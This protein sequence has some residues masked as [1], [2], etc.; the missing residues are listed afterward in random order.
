MTSVAFVGGMGRSGSTLLEQALAATP[1]VC[2]L[3]EVVHLWRRGVL[4]DELCS[5]GRPFSQ[6]PFWGAVGD[7]AFGGWRRADAERMIELHDRVDRMRFLPSLLAGDR[8]RRAADVRTYGEAFA[9]IYAAAAEVSGASLVVDSSK[10]AST[11]AV[12]RRTA[13]V[14]LKIVHVVRDSRGVAYSW[15]T[16][17]VRPE[18]VAGSEQPYMHRYR[19][20]ESAVLWDAH[21]LGFAA[22]ARLGVPT[23]RVHYEDLLTAPADRLRQL[24]EF[25]GLD[26]ADVDGI[27]SESTMT[28]S[29]SHQVSGNPV[30]FSGRRAVLQTDDRWRAQLPAGSRALVGALTAPL[31]LHYRYLGSGRR[32]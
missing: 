19:P 17:K 10:H 21:N 4:T 18:A 31:M 8:S 6:C 3:G 25:L 29:E 13:D 23:L 26:A 7:R 2:A 22:L 12:L 1:D 27:V 14:D 24:F 9:R 5:C 32:R 11:A 20:W 16:W 30:R 28:L 15:T